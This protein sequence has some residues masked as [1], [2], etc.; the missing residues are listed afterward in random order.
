MDINFYALNPKWTIKLEE[1]VSADPQGCLRRESQSFRVLGEVSEVA[2]PSPSR[3][4]CGFQRG[5]R[6]R[7]GR[8][9]RSR[10]G[11]IP[12]HRTLGLKKPGKMS[13]GSRQS[14]SVCSG[15]PQTSSICKRIQERPVKGD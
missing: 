10:I 14:K 9:P 7:E 3:A 5:L 15:Q 13:E 11:N 1:C 12:L 2:L 4:F 8:C 6:G